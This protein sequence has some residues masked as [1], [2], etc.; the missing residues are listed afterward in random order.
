MIKMWQQIGVE[1][2]GRLT[3]S[4][5]VRCLRMSKLLNSCF[6]L[7]HCCS[8]ITWKEAVHG[9]GRLTIDQYIFRVV[10]KMY[11]LQG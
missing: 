6:K 3:V 5:R 10:L 4:A 8:L 7:V 9:Y 2:G 1:E 11:H